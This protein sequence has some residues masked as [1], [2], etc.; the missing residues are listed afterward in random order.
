MNPIDTR[1]LEDHMTDCPEISDPFLEACLRLVSK[2]SSFLEAWHYRKQPLVIHSCISDVRIQDRSR[3]KPTWLR[4]WVTIHIYRFVG[5]II[6]GRHLSH[7]HW[8]ERG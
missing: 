5:S 7:P 4:S 2:G 1:F 3:V 6:D 8:I